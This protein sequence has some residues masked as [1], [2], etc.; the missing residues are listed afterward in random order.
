M[1]IRGREI[2]FLRTVKTA[3]DIAD[4]CP[5]KSLNNFAMLFNGSMADI[6]RNGAKLIHFMNEGYEMNR[7]F[8]DPTYEPKPITVEE[9]LYLDD[10]TYQ[11][12]FNEM[13]KA[14]TGDKQTVETEES[15]KNENVAKEE[16]N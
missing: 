3:C 11:Q 5:D 10:D 12:L 6:N 2:G 14:F 7:H 4:I 16:S 13:M 1:K 9:V 15:K 8:D